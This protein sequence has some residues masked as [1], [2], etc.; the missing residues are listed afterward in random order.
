[1]GKEWLRFLSHALVHHDEISV[2]SVDLI[3]TLKHIVIVAE[4]SSSSLCLA[5]NFLV[6]T[7][8]HVCSSSLSI[9]SYLSCGTH[10]RLRKLT[11]IKHAENTARRSHRL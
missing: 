10:L 4:I 8:S 9:L 1:M 11:V 6:V 5:V 2:I 3:L 7:C